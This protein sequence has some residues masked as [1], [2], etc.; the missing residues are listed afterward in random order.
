MLKDIG[1]KVETNR[2]LGLQDLTLSKLTNDMGCKAVFIGIGNPEPK[3]IP[4]FQGLSE[5]QGFFTSKSFLHG[6]SFCFCSSH[7]SRDLILQCLIYNYYIMK[8]RIATLL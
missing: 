1:V 8:K 6:A 7:Q 3:I 4:I 2:I 5:D